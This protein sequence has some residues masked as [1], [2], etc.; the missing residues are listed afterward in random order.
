MD[1]K[2]TE[3]NWIFDHLVLKLFWF[4]VLFGSQSLNSSLMECPYLAIKVKIIRHHWEIHTDRI[5]GIVYQLWKLQMFV[6]H[7]FNNKTNLSLKEVWPAWLQK[8]VEQIYH[9]QM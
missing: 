7:S 6:L 4:D 5:N 3:F 9:N 2:Q 1:R 8:L